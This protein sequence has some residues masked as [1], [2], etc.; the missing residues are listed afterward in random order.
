[1]CLAQS[2]RQPQGLHA[3]SADLRPEV[4]FRSVNNL[5][6]RDHDVRHFAA[7]SRGECIP[8]VSGTAPPV[9]D[10]AVVGK[11]PIAHSPEN[12]L[13]PAVDVDLAVEPA[14]VGL[15][16]VGTQVGQRRHFGV[17]LSL[18]DEGEDLRLAIGEPFAAAGPVAGR[19]ACLRAEALT[20]ISPA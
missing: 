10:S 16:R 6:D 20:T 9:L 17:V 7:S 5:S 1:M 3:T 11:E 15:D 4:H 12:G 19:V 18:R 8:D 14:D 2:A 13:G